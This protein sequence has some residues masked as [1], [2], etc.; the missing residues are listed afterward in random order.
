M[1]SDQASERA[2]DVTISIVIPAHNEAENLPILLRELC[3]TLAP[4]GRLEI[5]CVDD[6][7]TDNTFAVLLEAA[8]QDDRIKYVRLS[9]NFGHQAALRAGLS[10]ST[11]DCVISMDADMQHPV[12]LV[13]QM[14]EKWREGH[15]VVLTA[16]GETD[17]LTL[18]KRFT[19]KVFYLMINAL[20]DVHIDPGSADFRLLDRKVVDVVKSLSESD[21][22]LR[23]IIP[24]VGFKSCKLDY[25]PDRRR[26]GDTKY[27]LRKMI[28]FAVSGVV[29]NSIQPL[30]LATILSAIISGMAALYTLY[31]VHIYLVYGQVVPGWASVVVAVSFIGGLQLLVLGVVGEYIGRILK[32]SRKRPGFVVSAT[33][34]RLEAEK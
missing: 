11:G 20:S 19:S 4:L 3:A 27:S 1:M 14:V 2:L 18:F 5:V 10:Y 8:K 9:R 22:F 15:D 6:G 23:G 24:W 34:M 25:T 7:S 29:S 26:F 31:A 13:P 16:R 32:E 30:R 33:N 28:S 17:D 21:F 12:R